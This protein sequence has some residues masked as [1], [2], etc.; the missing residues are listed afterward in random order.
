[1]EEIRNDEVLTEEI[2]EETTEV[3]TPDY[4]DIVPADDDEPRGSNSAVIFA[5]GA[6]VACAIIGGIALG[7]KIKSKFG[8]KKKDQ[9]V[10]E[11][12]EDDEVFEDEAEEPEQVEEDPKEDKKKK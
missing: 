3:Y 10:L 5:A 11:E 9:E 7:K 1:M 2:Q 8:A 4:E 12:S 6:L